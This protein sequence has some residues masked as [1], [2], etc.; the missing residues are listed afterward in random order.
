[1]KTRFLTTLVLNLTLAFTTRCPREESLV[2]RWGEASV[3]QRSRDT[4]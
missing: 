4:Q 3:L 2:S 1:M